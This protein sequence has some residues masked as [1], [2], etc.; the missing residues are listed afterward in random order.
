M[1][2]VINAFAQMYRYNYGAI[3]FAIASILTSHIIL[4]RSEL[5]AWCV[6]EFYVF[7]CFNP[8]ISNIHDSTCVN[9]RG[10]DYVY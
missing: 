1:T 4:A 10:H 3:A 6:C 5:V 8:P 7:D 9:I 2:K